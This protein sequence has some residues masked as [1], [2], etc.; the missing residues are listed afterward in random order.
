MG[1]VLDAEDVFE[2]IVSNSGKSFKARLRDPG[3]S[4]PH[5][6]HFFDTSLYN[7][8]DDSKYVSFSPHSKISVYSFKRSIGVLYYLPGPIR[9]S[10]G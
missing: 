8:M 6:F 3:L 5:L 7:S 10:C 9:P 1:P 2:D 4:V